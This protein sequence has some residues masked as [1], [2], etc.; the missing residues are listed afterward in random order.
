MLK[1]LVLS[2]SYVSLSLQ[3]WGNPDADQQCLYACVR[4]FYGVTFGTYMET[5]DYYTGFCQDSLH[6]QSGYLCAKQ[7]CTPSQIKTGIEY[8]QQYWCNEATPTPVKMFSYEDVIAN[9][10]DADIANMQV[11]DFPYEITDIINNTLLI[12]DRLYHASFDTNVR[13]LFLFTKI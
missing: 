7:R 9:Y 2:L 12:T 6:I 8:Y 1:I 4:A 3:S 11:I 10:S 13:S 5:D